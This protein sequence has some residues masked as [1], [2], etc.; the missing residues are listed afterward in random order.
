[1]MISHLSYPFVAT[2]VETS[3]TRLLYQMILRGL[4]TLGSVMGFLI[5]TMNL[6]KSIA[7]VPKTNFNAV[8]VEILVTQ[9]VNHYFRPST[10]FQKRKLVMDNQIVL[11]KGMKEMSK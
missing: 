2:V 1:M 7:I 4:R 5:V 11:M 6:T 3:I 9:V 10:A 8:H